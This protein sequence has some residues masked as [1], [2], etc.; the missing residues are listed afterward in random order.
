MQ[1]REWIISATAT[2][3][4]MVCG[5]TALAQGKFP[6]RTITMDLPQFHGRLNVSKLK[7]F[8]CTR[9]RVIPRAGLW[10][11]RSAPLGRIASCP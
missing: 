10:T 7:R 4:T 2:V 11:T 1:R 3:V 5:Q 8:E 6:E 9:A